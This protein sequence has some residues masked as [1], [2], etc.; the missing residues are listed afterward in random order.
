MAMCHVFRARFRWTKII[1]LPAQSPLVPRTLPAPIGSR[2]SSRRD[3]VDASPP[4]SSSRSKKVLDFSSHHCQ[5]RQPRGPGPDAAQECGWAAAQPRRLRPAPGPPGG[6]PCR[7]L[8]GQRRDARPASG[9]P[10]R[11]NTGD[12]GRAA[13]PLFKAEVY[14]PPSLRLLNL[15]ATEEPPS[16]VPDNQG[17]PVMRG[18]RVVLYSRSCCWDC[19]KLDS[20]LQSCQETTPSGHPGD[21]HPSVGLAGHH[22]RH[23]RHHEPS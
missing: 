7:R 3:R 4:H 1:R 21:S 15:P 10:G 5:G 11:Y 14:L 23:Q 20:P 18:V 22:T 12:P 8:R 19:R 16:D 6:L 13:L 2:W 17:R 9:R